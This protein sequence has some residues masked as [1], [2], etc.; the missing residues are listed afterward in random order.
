MVEHPAH[1]GTN[2]GSNPT[3][4]IFEKIDKNIF[5]NYAFTSS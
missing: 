1:N 2:V 5:I 3:K 4:P